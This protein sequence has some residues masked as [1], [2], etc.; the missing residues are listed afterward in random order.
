MN[1]ATP[2]IPTA[3]KGRE[4]NE[5]VRHG[6]PHAG[7]SAFLCAQ[8]ELRTGGSNGNPEKLSVKSQ[9]PPTC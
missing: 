3:H 4:H 7:T 2:N 9:K 8:V 5:T 6:E 1:V